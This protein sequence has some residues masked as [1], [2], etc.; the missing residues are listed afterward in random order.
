MP[1][2]N[3]FFLALLVWTFCFLLTGVLRRYAV[4]RRI[5]DIPNERSSHDRPTPRGG[6]LSISLAV[7]SGA[8]VIGFIEDNMR[9][10]AL[11]LAGGGI[12]ISI[13]GWLDDHKDISPLIR[14]VIYSVA[15]VWAVYWL[16]DIQWTAAATDGYAP[17][18]IWNILFV[19]GTVWLV[20]LYN[21]M[22]G[23]DALAAL[24]TISVAA[25]GALFYYLSAHQPL[26][27]LGVILVCSS[28]GF[29]PWNWPPAK[30]FMGDVGSCL[31]GFVMAIAALYGELTG[32][33]PLTVWGVLLAVFIG[34][35]S[36]T[37]LY[38]VFKGETWYKAH[39]SHAYQR[40]VQM[41]LSHKKLALLV[42]G[43]NILVLGPLAYV[44]FSRPHYRAAVFIGVYTVLGILWYLIQSAYARRSREG[45]GQ[46]V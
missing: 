27:M 31:I 21:F 29:L 38:R 39:R 6:G 42:F 36:F 1:I 33:V 4:N 22:D 18:M 25:F 5:I 8:V 37:L 26:F 2:K 32:A 14:L 30:I 41:G 16:N 19:T 23:T 44:V 20:N 43:L 24:E 46:A 34:D 3:Y 12:A 10:F 15:A 40:L 13:I 17:R 9:Q 28:A 45:A 7:T 11:A 35:A